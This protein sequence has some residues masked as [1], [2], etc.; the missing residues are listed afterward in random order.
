M[1]A[2]TDIR[3]RGE[4]GGH[5]LCDGGRHVVGLLLEQGRGDAGQDVCLGPEHALV[6]NEVERAER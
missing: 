3:V 5:V 6:F 2:H 1:G 4:G